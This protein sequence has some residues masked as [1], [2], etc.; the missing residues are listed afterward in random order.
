MAT[1]LS[2][3][4]TKLLSGKQF[5]DGNF[6]DRTPVRENTKCQYNNP[7]NGKESSR[8]GTVNPTK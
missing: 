7:A 4:G 5:R 1:K 2:N 8:R 6:K 3:A